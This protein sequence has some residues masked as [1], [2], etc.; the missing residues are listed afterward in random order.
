MTEAEL[1]KWEHELNEQQVELNKKA[2]RLELEEKKAETG[3]QELFE[4]KFS[5]IKN[6][7]DLRQT[8]ITQ[9]EA[10]LANDEIAF[11]TKMDKYSADVI[12]K[13][14]AQTEKIRS[15]ESIKLTD[16][17]KKLRD[18]N[19]DLIQDLNQKIAQL[20]YD[21]NTAKNEGS[22]AVS[23]QDSNQ[24]TINELENQIKNLTGDN[25][26]NK[27]KCIS[28]QEEKDVLEKAAKDRLDQISILQKNLK[29]FENLEKLLNGKSLDFYIS[30]I[31][32]LKDKQDAVSQQDEKNKDKESDLNFQ[33]QMIRTRLNRLEQNET[34]FNQRIEEKCQERIDVL[35]HDLE[36]LRQEKESYRIQ[37]ENIK[38]SNHIFEDYQELGEKAELLKENESLKIELKEIAAK[39]KRFPSQYVEMELKD[40]E[41]SK[42]RLENDKRDIEDRERVCENIQKE[43]Y[44]LEQELDTA[45]FLLAQTQKSNETLRYELNRFTSGNIQDIEN[46]RIRRIE[47]INKPLAFL[48]GDNR[49]KRRQQ[50]PGE[51]LNEKEW[52]ENIQK[53]IKEFGLYFPK[54]IINAFHTALKCSDISP[55][56]VLGGTSG[57]GKSELVRLY[58][59]FGGLTFLSLPVQPDWD[60]QEDMLGFFNSIDNRFEA[61]DVLRLLAQTQRSP[62][63]QEGLNDV[64]T[65]ILLD[66]MNL[67]NP[68][69]YFADF[70]SK[71]ETRRGLDEDHLPAIPVKIGSGLEPEPIMLGRNVLWTG[72]MNNDETTKTLSDKVIDRGILI[73]FPRPK[74][75]ERRVEKKILGAPAPLLSRDTWTLWTQAAVKFSDEEIKEYKL[76]IQQI[77]DELGKTGRGLGHRV[78]Q[79]IETYMSNYPDVIDAVEKKDEKAKKKAMDIAFED[80][81]V[82][83]VMPKLRGIENRGTQGDVLENIEKLIPE[84]LKADYRNA[85]DMSYGQFMWCT[86][87]YMNETAKTEEENVKKNDK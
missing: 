63:E 62:E 13:V 65:V 23:T 55:L 79:S 77:N 12:E 41:E 3:Y 59:H 85:K 29:Q 87:D 56:T 42:Q 14:K 44:R 39:I 66:E 35:M 67:S 70:L 48:S 73:N 2:A 7:L 51:K 45:N 82:Q 60:C 27:Q 68:E 1:K 26:K 8:E 84:N 10:K 53:K 64:M 37:L 30:E 57:T 4:K 40:D 17:L 80:Q 28:L 20:T 9:K 76:T 15:E 81:I 24:K 72:T 22:I 75:F 47:E 58:S 33:E 54:R 50:N 52:L 36:S 16:E 43:K 21:L 6:S 25:E 34:D 46:E 38:D 31:S 69:L 61:Q 74:V 49:P 83:K 11:K 32:S 86:S 18:S 71:L 78:W 5:E 19:T